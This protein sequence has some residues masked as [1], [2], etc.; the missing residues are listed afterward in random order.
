[1]A[2]RIAFGPEAIAVLISI[3]FV[4]TVVLAASAQDQ[5][6][7]AVSSLAVSIPSASRTS[8]SVTTTAVPA[9]TAS[10]QAGGSG[11]ASAP[12]PDLVAIQ[13][14]DDSIILERD[15]LE[16]ARTLQD[17]VEIARSLRQINNLLVP[18]G[19]VLDRL[20]KGGTTSNVTIGSLRD[21]YERLSQA[22]EVTL[23]FSTSAVGAYE[24]GALH[25]IAILDELAAQ[26]PGGRPA[27]T[28]SASARP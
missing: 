24:D 20:A 11:T 12:A 13:A 8:A 22:I 28:P 27:A 5:P 23:Q 15:D 10:T 6:G 14:I 7:P 3:L 18:V 9:P 1:V 25:V 26:D 16:R 2:L 19:A 4:A 21:V 17:A